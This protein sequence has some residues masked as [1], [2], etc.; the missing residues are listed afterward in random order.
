MVILIIHS[1]VIDTMMIMRQFSLRKNKT[2]S[3]Q[4]NPPL[5]IK[6][7]EEIKKRHLL[8]RIRLIIFVRRTHT[9]FTYKFQLVHILNT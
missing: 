6:K 4:K 9:K 7:K 3:Y 8:L 5:I 1:T 2:P